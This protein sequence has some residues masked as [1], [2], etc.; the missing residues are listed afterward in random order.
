VIS[1]ALGVA[2]FVAA[3]ALDYAMVRYQEAV[4]LR[5]GHR[6][7]LWSVLVYL[8]GAVGFLSV[9]K[10]SLWFILPECIGLYVGTRLAVR[11]H[12]TPP[13]PDVPS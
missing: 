1:A 6:A 7:A 3:A 9:A 8:V 11:K 5:L 13:A 4:T 2:V 12:P 10:A